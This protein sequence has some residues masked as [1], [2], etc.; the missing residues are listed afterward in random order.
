[1]YPSLIWFSLFQPPFILM[2][3][4]HHSIRTD[5]DWASLCHFSGQNL[6]YMLCMLSAPARDLV[7]QWCCATIDQTHFL[8]AIASPST[9]PCQWVSGSVID[10]FR[11]QIAIASPSFATL[12][13]FADWC[14][15]MLIN[16]DWC[17]LML[18]DADWCWL[19]LIDVDWCWFL[20]FYQGVSAGQC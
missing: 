3:V 1:M 13:N 10:S 16:A 4:C 15:L 5:Q 6:K 20:C 11:F 7:L 12:F 18:M 14:W 19:I 17:W 8:D 2:T 9:Y